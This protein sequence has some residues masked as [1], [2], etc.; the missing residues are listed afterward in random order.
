[1][2]EIIIIAGP[3]GAGKTSFANE[4]LSSFRGRFVFLN[5]DEIA[6]DIGDAGIPQTKLDLHAGREM[7]TRIDEC[8]EA[9]SN[10]LFETTLA[11]LTHARKVTG[12]RAA[13]CMVALVYLR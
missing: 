7:L 1:M 2:Q 13:G 8:I 9:G 4:Y 5:A 3:N 11:T 12:W 10:L 6:R